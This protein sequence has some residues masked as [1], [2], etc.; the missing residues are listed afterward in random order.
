M[1]YGFDTVGAERVGCAGTAAD[2]PRPVMIAV[3]I[4]AFVPKREQD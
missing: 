1:F 2:H 3:R 4:F